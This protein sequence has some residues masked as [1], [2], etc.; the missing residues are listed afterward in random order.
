MKTC[1]QRTLSFFGSALFFVAS[2]YGAFAQSGPQSA[3][4]SY[5]AEPGTYKLISENDQFRVIAVTRAAGHRDAWHSH[6]GALV[7]YGLSDCQTRIHT[8][9]GKSA[10]G[11]SVVK[12]GTVIFNPATASHAA[13]NTGTA[14][15]RQL[16]VE[17]K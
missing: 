4:P 13:E 12:A 15:C 16:I 9:D 5:V 8:P 6:A 2:G 7:V 1:T 3:P 17:R 11:D 14:E 10:G